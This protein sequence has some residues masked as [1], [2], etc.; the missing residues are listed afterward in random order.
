MSENTSVGGVI[1]DK[2]GTW[3]SAFSKYIGC[4]FAL[5]VEFWGARSL[6]LQQ[7]VLEM[8]SMAVVHLIQAVLGEF[9]HSAI[10]AQL[11]ISFSVLGW[12]G[13]HT[14]SEKVTESPMIWQQWCFQNLRAD[15][16]ICNP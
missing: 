1:R 6:G 8:D 3:I 12:F 10:Y 13:L 2:H 11:K 5:N 9:H 15:V 16:F 4:C 14:S 7:V